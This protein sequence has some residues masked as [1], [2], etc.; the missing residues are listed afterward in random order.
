M[1]EPSLSEKALARAEKLV[2]RGVDKTMDT[3]RQSVGEGLAEAKRAFADFTIGKGHASAMGRLGLTELRNALDPSSDG[4]GISDSEIGILGTATQG[5]IARGRAEDEGTVHGFQNH[6]EEGPR[7][8]STVHG[9]REEG[10][11]SLLSQAEV[12][13]V[14]TTRSV[15]P[16]QE[17]ER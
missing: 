1:S 10:N 3:V 9:N 17:V 12:K 8:E 13:A 7:E 16:E 14:Q 2:M 4:Q 11:S 15:A 6:E 5:E